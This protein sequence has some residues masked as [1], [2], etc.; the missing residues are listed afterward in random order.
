M[1]K[2]E[3]KDFLIGFALLCFAISI[4]FNLTKNTE[5]ET[6]QDELELLESKVD[7][8]H[9]ANDQL[10]SDIFAYKNAIESYEKE[11]LKIKK[12]I[13]EIRLEANEKINNVPELT[14]PEL[15]EFFTERYPSTTKSTG[16]KTG[17][18]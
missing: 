6:Y 18:N 9:F 1:M 13:K 17:N 14:L 10:E 8:L 7:S 5:I 15:E 3:H 16:S 11:I 4:G 2:E 12:N